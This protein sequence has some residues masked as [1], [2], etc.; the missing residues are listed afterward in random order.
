MVDY[1]SRIKAHRAKFVNKNGTKA[2]YYELKFDRPKKKEPEEEEWVKNLHYR[3]KRTAGEI[4]YEK[5]VL[6]QHELTNK[7]VQEALDASES[8]EED[9]VHM[10]NTFKAI[11]DKYQYCLQREKEMLAAARAKR[12]PA[13]LAE[14]K[15]MR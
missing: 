10:K 3:K 2:V 5:D 13:L 4:Q 9:I 12:T 15:K 11:T 1:S 14:A 6:E 8:V 7:M